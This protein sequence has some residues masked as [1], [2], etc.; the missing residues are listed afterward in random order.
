M[1]LRFL[2]LKAERRTRGP[3][4]HSVQKVHS[5]LGKLFIAAFDG[6]VIRPP[7]LAASFISGQACDVADWHETDMARCLT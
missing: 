3:L 2:L 7:Q 6:L 1:I 5:H 4:R